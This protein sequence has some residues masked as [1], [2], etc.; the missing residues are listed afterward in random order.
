MSSAAFDFPQGSAAQG[1][2]VGGLDLLA[3]EARKEGRL[4]ASLRCGR[5]SN[6]YVVDCEAY[7]T[8]GVL[9]VAPERRSY[10]FSE[11]HDAEQ[12]IHEAARALEYLGCAVE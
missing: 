4:V 11:R 2:A 5:S 3:R 9:R 6:G 8:E 10:P 7:T 12:F 1:T